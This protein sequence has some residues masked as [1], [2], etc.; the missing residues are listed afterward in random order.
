MDETNRFGA[1]RWLAFI[2]AA[3][4]IALLV[5]WLSHLAGVSVRTLASIAVGAIALAW[6]I[7]LVAV[8]WNLYF[9]ARRVVIQMAVSRERGIVIPDSAEA[10]ARRIAK[11][12]LWFALGGHVVTAVVAA[13]ITYFAGGTVGYYVTGFYLFS[14]LIRPAIAYFA[15]LRERIRALARESTHP[16]EDVVSL[17]D[18]MDELTGSFKE[19]TADQRSLADDL[20]RAESRLADDIAHARQL[21]TADLARLTDAQASDRAST[22]SREEDLGRRIDL[23]VRR[24]QDTLDGLSDHAELQA[25]IRALVRMIQAD[26]GQSS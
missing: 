17:R 4:A 18:R 21:M 2:V 14:V 22:R 11:R 3:T 25:G 1:I 24:M 13:V 9:G 6:L 26:A 10:E 12:M 16:R 5:T 7:V 23:I 20:R 19:L 8:P 15:H